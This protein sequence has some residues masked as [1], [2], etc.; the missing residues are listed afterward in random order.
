[1]ANS[2]RMVISMTPEMISALKRQSKREQRTISTL[3][4]L[5]IAQWLE[6]HGDV[7][8]TDITWGGFRENEQTGTD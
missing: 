8:T 2:Q 7:V 5:A 3:I 1:M 4:R 6:Q